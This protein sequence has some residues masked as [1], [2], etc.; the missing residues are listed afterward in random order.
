[1]FRRKEVTLGLGAVPGA[2]CCITQCSPS[3][4]TGCRRPS[5]FL[6]FLAGSVLPSPFFPP[7]KHVLA[8]L[9]TLRHCLVLQKGL[10]AEEM[11]QSPR[12]GAGRESSWG[13][14][15]GETALLASVSQSL[16]AGPSISTEVLGP[17]SC[18][19]VWRVS[20]SGGGHDGN[21]C[22]HWSSLYV[23]STRSPEGGCW[24]AC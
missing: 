20:G 10:G 1:M 4:L 7:L 17:P 14:V 19:V 16:L 23:A 9:M 11:P 12:E 21:W 8:P 5:P 2:P 22:P 18:P 15:C 13:T 6:F 24:T 3:R